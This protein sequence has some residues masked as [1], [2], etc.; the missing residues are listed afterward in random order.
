MLKVGLKDSLV[1]KVFQLL[2]E[3]GIDVNDDDEEEEDQQE[4]EEDNQG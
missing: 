2:E 4:E 1:S 3:L